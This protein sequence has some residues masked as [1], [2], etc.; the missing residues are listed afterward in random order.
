MGSDFGGGVVLRVCCL[1]Y[2]SITEV[3]SIRSAYRDA[4][5]NEWQIG[6]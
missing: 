6:F 2:R 4:T 5:P 1:E 3:R